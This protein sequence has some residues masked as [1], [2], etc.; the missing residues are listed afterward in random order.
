MNYTQSNRKLFGDSLSNLN[1]ASTSNNASSNTIPLELQVFQQTIFDTIIIPLLK[2]EDIFLKKNAFIISLIKQNF[3]TI[4]KVHGKNI[5]LSFYTNIIDLVSLTF[6]KFELAMKYD[7]LF[8]PKDGTATL[9]L[10]VKRVLMKSEYEIYNVLFGKPRIS[11]RY[12]KKII[13]AIKEII[14]EKK[15]LTLENIKFELRKK[16]IYNKFI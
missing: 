16:R 9:G 7:D 15:I 8:N 3:D 6:D 11:Q 12:S 14:Y 2:D 13:K 10:Q 5:D 1:L 4:S